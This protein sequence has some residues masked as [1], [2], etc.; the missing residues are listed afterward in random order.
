MRANHAAFSVSG[1]KLARMELAAK[2]AQFVAGK[3]LLGVGE[4]VLVGEIGTE[5]GGIVGVERDQ[6]AAIEVAAQGM[7][8]ERGADAGADVGGGIQFEWSAPR[9]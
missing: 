6:Q 7:G 9:F 8:G 4:Q 1:R 3:A 2:L 5:E